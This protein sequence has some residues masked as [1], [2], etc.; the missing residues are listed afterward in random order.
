MRTGSKVSKHLFKQQ[1]VASEETLD[2][3]F[4]RAWATHPQ[5]IALADPPDRNSFTSGT[6]QRLSY[7][8]TEQRVRW[9]AA[10]LVSSGISNNDI[11]LTQLPNIAEYVVI[12]LAIARIGAVISPLPLTLDNEQL[13][14]T[15]SHTHPKAYIGTVLN[16]LNLCNTVRSELPSYCRILSLAASEESDISFLDINSAY[17][18]EERLSLINH[19]EYTDPLSEDLYSISPNAQDE[20]IHQS[21]SHWLQAASLI[22][23]SADLPENGTLLCPIPLDSMAGVGVYLYNWLLSSARLVLHHSQNASLFIDQVKNEHADY[24]LALPLL[25]S[26]LATHPD[27]LDE[28]REQNP[29]YR[30]EIATPSAEQVCSLSGITYFLT[31]QLKDSSQAPSDN[32]RLQ[33]RY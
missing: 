33:L 7:E 26:G 27:L 13:K 3:L 16:G 22:Y 6:P 14:N 8:E 24:A 17:T 10:R 19:M 18:P 31:Q 21:H 2:S 4:R 9:T 1:D 15:V 23:E 11:V 28:S 12:Y 25:T 29:A 5:R 32:N 20:F 30:C